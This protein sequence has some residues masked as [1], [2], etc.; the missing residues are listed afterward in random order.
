MSTS[1]AKEGA[2][3]SSDRSKGSSINFLEDDPATMTYSRRIALHL[4][5]KKWYF[6]KSEKEDEEDV[7]KQVTAR[8]LE[9]VPGKSFEE[10]L[11]MKEEKQPSLEEA[12]A[13]FEHVTLPRYLF[14]PKPPGWVKRSP[15][16]RFKNKM[17][18]ANKKMDIAEPGEKDRATRLY[19]PIFTPLKQMG[20]FGLGIGLY[21][22]TLR[23][24]TVMTFLAGLINI[25]NII[26]YSGSEY[27]A[28]QPDVPW[29]LKGSAIC[30][31][32]AWVP[33]TTCNTSESQGYT[34]EYYRLAN[35]TNEHGTEIVFSMKNTCNAARYKVGLVNL[36]TCFFIVAG[37]AYMNYYQ[38][39][40]EVEFD[41]DEQTAQDYSVIIT[42]PPPDANDPQEWKDFF[43]KNF[44]NVHVTCCTVAIDNDFLVR[45]LVKRRE[46]LQ[47]MKLITPPGTSLAPLDL[48]KLSTSI[49]KNRNALAKFLAI[50]APG[51]PEYYGQLV[52]L[53]SS[54][55]GVAQLD[56]SEFPVNNIF[57]TFETEA[58]QR[59]V[60][61]ALTVPT[62]R[63]WKQDTS[64]IAN[65]HH[66]FRKE[67]VLQIC[68]AEE[69]STI[70]YVYFNIVFKILFLTK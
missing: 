49:Q 7:P 51:I 65:P 61:A 27:S 42:N 32:Q 37:I 15:L 50:L 31:E 12:W 18:K 60:L 17:S 62:Y 55:Q 1:G 68:E 8:D 64:V 14:R 38:K 39:K 36:G 48:A 34:T 67:R 30:T 40:M 4:M 44:D 33:C 66:L 3:Q 19:S 56:K 53:N 52:V 26:F 47:K 70:R 5:N 21:F 25:P 23:A 29:L 35:T 41:E 58:A 57:I 69:P 2:S 28:G 46:L 13:Y 54:I 63:I 10:S 9:D 20:D 24:I 45:C 22:S 11:G 6:P 16:V 59:Q 43:E